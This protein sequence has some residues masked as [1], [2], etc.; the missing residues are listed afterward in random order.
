MKQLLAIGLLAVMTGSAA[1]NRT[2]YE[3]G[4]PAR[5]PEAWSFALGPLGAMLAS[6]Y[7]RAPQGAFAGPVIPCRLRRGSGTAGEI[8]LTYSCR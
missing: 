6:D 8:R 5:T 1:A 4:P 7:L 2:P 3:P